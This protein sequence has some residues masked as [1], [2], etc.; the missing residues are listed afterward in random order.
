MNLWLEPC[1][2]TY[3]AQCRAAME[4]L[5]SCQFIVLSQAASRQGMVNTADPSAA[6]EVA[7]TRTALLL[8]FETEP[9]INVIFEA[10]SFP[11]T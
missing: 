8:E 3:S 4:R 7:V 6:A 2:A 10:V 9:T 5:P 1:D 11:T